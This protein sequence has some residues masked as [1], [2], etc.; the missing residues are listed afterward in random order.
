V[1]TVKAVVAVAVEFDTTSG[2]TEYVIEA[3]VR[4]ALNEKGFKVNDIQVERYITDASEGVNV[5][6]VL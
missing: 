2:V 3:R 1:N 4:N 6:K 5:E